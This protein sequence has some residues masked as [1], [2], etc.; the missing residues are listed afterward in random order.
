MA[1]RRRKAPAKKRKSSKKRSSGVRTNAFGIKFL[2]KSQTK[3]MNRAMKRAGEAPLKVGTCRQISKRTV[4]VCRT[5]RGY[6][7]LTSPHERAR[8]PGVIAPRSRRVSPYYNSDD[9]K[10]NGTR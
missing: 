4:I 7:I 2:T 5:P 1:K 3:A 10:L 8:A 9:P 6:N